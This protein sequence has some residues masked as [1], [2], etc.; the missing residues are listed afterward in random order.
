MAVV[1]QSVFISRPNKEL[2]NLYWI[3]GHS[4]VDGNEKA[5]KL[6]NEASNRSSAPQQEM[7]PEE[8]KIRTENLD[9]EH[10]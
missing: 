8:K 7:S 3:K 2:K 9:F 6:A 1:S 4:G 10:P 5:D